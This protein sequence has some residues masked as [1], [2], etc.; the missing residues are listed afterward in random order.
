MKLSND[1]GKVVVLLFWNSGVAEAS[2]ILEMAAAM[3]KKFAGKPFAVIGVNND[4]T[5]TLRDMCKQADLVTFPNFSDP[6]NRLAH[7]YRVG[8][9]PLAYVLD[10]E[11]KIHY[12]G[13]PGS[14]V[15]ITVTG[16]LEQVKPAAK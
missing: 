4:P 15:D 3:S 14:F 6:Q 2:R 13:P 11:R 9:W 10:G 16:L 7:E 12:A 8:T 1:A 5:S